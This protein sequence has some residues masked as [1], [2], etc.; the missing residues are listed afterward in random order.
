MLAVCIRILMGMRL[1]LSIPS[2]LDVE[3]NNA[4]LTSVVGHSTNFDVL[5]AVLELDSEAC[6]VGFVDRSDD[7]DVGL[8]F[9]WSTRPA[10]I[11]VV[12]SVVVEGDSG[13]G[14]LELV[15]VAQRLSNIASSFL[16]AFGSVCILCVMESV[17]VIA[18][19]VIGRAV[20]LPCLDGCVS[21]I[22]SFSTV[23]AQVIPVIPYEI[24]YNLQPSIFKFR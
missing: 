8:W 15:E 14:F 18:L 17:A 6:M 5:S 4:T 23:S 3:A 16:D 20:F 11:H 19:L 24:N 12:I 21:P 22:L 7:R 10:I 2:W 1:S 13:S 9:R